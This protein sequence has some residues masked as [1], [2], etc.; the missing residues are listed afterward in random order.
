M[1]FEIILV[2]LIPAIFSIIAIYI[3]HKLDNKP[4]FLNENMCNYAIELDKICFKVRKETNADNVYIAEFHNTGKFVRG[5]PMLKYSVVA[6]DYSINGSSNKIKQHILVSNFPY[7]IHR[8]IVDR[9]Y[10]CEDINTTS[11]KDYRDCILSK[12]MTTVYSFMLIN[13]N[14]KQYLGFIS[15]EYKNKQDYNKF[16][17]GVL[18]DLKTDILNL[19]INK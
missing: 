7:F 5:V 3:K 6:D 15:L 11:D 9:K 10:I 19:M 18:L 8:L 17:D 1:N 2:A 13:P 4:H 12:G 16:D 14:N